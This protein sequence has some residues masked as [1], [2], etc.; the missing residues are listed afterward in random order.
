MF[1]NTGLERVAEKL[2]GTPLTTN[3]T[4][5]FSSFDK[6]QR[7]LE[8]TGKHYASSLPTIAV[9]N[10]IQRIL[11][12]TGKHYISSLPTIAVTNNIQRILEQTG[13]HYISSLPTIAVTNNIQR[14]LE[15][16][17]KHYISSLPT[18]AVT[19]NIQ[20]ILEQ[21]GKHYISSLPT[22]AVTNV[23]KQVS[24]D[25]QGVE[26]IAVELREAEDQESVV[27]I[28]VAYSQLVTAAPEVGVDGM[29]LM[30]PAHD[31]YAR[32]AVQLAVMMAYL[33]AAFVFGLAAAHYPPL[34]AFLWMSGFAPKPRVVWTATGAAYD[35]IFSPANNH[36]PQE[37]ST[38]SIW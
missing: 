29:D 18:I 38:K 19:N 35:R 5:L 30:V 17:G 15:Q 4:D 23:L 2:E 32:A 16:T 14:I 34:S 26:E 36:L 33:S 24:G 8:Q 3:T 20:R 9:T 13:K 1:A 28:E 25:F 37:P 31:R 27:A 11:E 22:I 21:T 6:I 10:N 12:Q 7:V